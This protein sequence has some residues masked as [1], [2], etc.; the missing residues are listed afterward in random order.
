MKG[1]IV[2]PFVDCWEDTNQALLDACHQLDTKVDVL[3]IDN[4]S[5]DKARAEAERFASFSRGQVRLW[6]H[7]PPMPSLAATWNRALDYAWEAGYDDCMVWNND[8]RVGVRMYAALRAVADAQNLWFAT[9]VNCA[10]DDAEKWKAMNSHWI[11]VEHGDPSLGGPDFSCFLITRECHQAYRFDERFQPAYFEDGDFH[12]RHWLNGDGAKIA[13]VTLPYLHYGSRTIHR[14]EEAFRAF[15]PQFQAC[16]ER[17]I[18]KWGGLP[19]RETRIGPPDTAR[20]LLQLENVGTPGGYLNGW[21][22]GNPVEAPCVC[23][24]SGFERRIGLRDTGAKY[25]GC[26]FCTGYANSEQ[27]GGALG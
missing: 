4:G 1:L 23:G 24:A 10:G 7:R 13:G 25:V 20:A 21:Y 26:A 9:P 14:S 5:G 19:H 12:R 16:R 27:D 17:Y 8:I 3:L 15:Q 11:Q 6:Q 22:P 18:A 2:I